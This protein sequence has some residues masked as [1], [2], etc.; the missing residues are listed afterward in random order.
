MSRRTNQKTTAAGVRRNTAGYLALVLHAH[1]PYVRHPELDGCFEENWLFEA[2][3]ECYVPLIDLFDRLAEDRVDFRLTLSVSPTLMA[4]LN[5]ELLRGRYLSH[6]DAMIQL[7]E[8][9]I[10][11][12]R[13]RPDY[14][15]LARCYRRLFI[16][17]RSIYFDRYGCDLLAGFN[18]HRLAGRLELMTTAAT[19]GFLPLLNVSET[20]VCNQIGI[21]VEV[22]RRQFGEAPTGFWLPECGYYPGLEKLLKEAGLHHFFVDSHAVTDTDPPPERGVYAPVD[23]G[24]GVLAFG[25]DPEAARQVWCAETGYPGAADYRE[26]YSDLGFESDL[27]SI[28][29]YLPAPETRINTGIKYH[30]VTGGTGPKAVYEPKKALSKAYEHAGDF[31]ERRLQRFREYASDRA[32]FPLPMSVAP[33][34]AELFGHWWFEGPIWLERVIRLCA[35]ETSEIR[36]IAGSDYASLGSP[37]AVVQPCASSW[38]KDG[39]SGY[40]INESNDWIYPLIHRAE[41]EMEKLASDLQGLTVD[42]LQ[43]RALNQAAR[44]LLLAQASD[45]PFMLKSGT[46]AEYA[47]KNLTDHLARFNYLID[48][49]RKNRIDERYLT[50]LEIMDAVFPD[51]DFR[52]YAAPGKNRFFPGPE[53]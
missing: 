34:D 50:A 51:I 9:E 48:C 11:R 14:A 12:H 27:A 33:F 10:A 6:L 25:R 31:V 42:P 21:G 49:I 8:T 37:V 46:T 3:T 45:W 22:F 38:G 52:R 23:C 35:D 17:L 16:K 32:K 1:L 4:M 29:P 24:N 18:Q 43:Q 13:E 39:Y 5:D 47:R 40:W 7:A 15:K 2:L 20:A 26:F 30:S 41:A 19:H 53:N 28:A 44:S 36:L